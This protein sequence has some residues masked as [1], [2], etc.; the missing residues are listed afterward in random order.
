[1]KEI[2]AAEEN[3]WLKTSIKA[4][5]ARASRRAN[6]FSEKDDNTDNRMQMASPRHSPSANLRVPELYRFWKI[7]V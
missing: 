5:L 7:P 1:M 2:P 3:N 4:P 6:I